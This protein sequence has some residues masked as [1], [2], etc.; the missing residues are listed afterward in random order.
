[1]RRPSFPSPPPS[2]DPERRPSVELGAGQV[3]IPTD[4]K[5]A[6]VRH[7]EDLYRLTDPHLSELGLESLLDTILTRIRQ[8]LAVDTVAVLLKDPAGEELVARA[9]KGLEAEVEQRVRI[10]IG[11]GFAGRIAA[12]R[13]AIFIP[14]VGQA[15]VVNPILRERGIRSM[16]GVPL[17]VEGELIGVLHVGSLTPRSFGEGDAAL[18]ALAAAR[19]APAIERARLSD[20]LTHHRV[21]AEALQ[22]G[23]L[24]EAVP[25]LP[26]VDVAVRYI[27]ARDEVGGD[28][29]EVMPLPGGRTGFVIGDVV[30]HGVRAAALMGQ[31][32]AVLRSAA[33]G[34]VQPAVVVA[35][36][37]RY[38]Q[39]AHP[40]G[41]ATVLYAVLDP[42]RG[43]LTFVRAGHPPLA[44]VGED[45]A[46]LVSGGASPPIGALRYPR[47]TEATVPLAPG[48]GVL[49]YTDGLVERRGESLDV[50]F[51]RLLE[52]AEGDTTPDL[53]CGR[54]ID[55]LIGSFASE[56]DVAVVAFRRPLPTPDLE[57]ESPATPESLAPTRR[58]LR[59]WLNARGVDA[60]DAT[61]IVLAT[62][63]A[64]ANAVEHAHAG[65]AGGRY[66][67][68]ATHAGDVVT[69]TVADDGD[70]R[71]PR[72][73]SDR[74]RGLPMIRSA[75]DRLVLDRD[76][77]GTRLTMTRA[78]G[79]GARR[80]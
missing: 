67:L 46:R 35:E 9:A 56:D 12:A 80:A 44:I 41:M 10:P 57:L 51:A 34:S 55:R 39:H 20:E 15:D 40:A 59:A 37:D 29:Y 75:M 72:S 32:R 42:D 74:G 50:G 71:V 48:D 69:V 6:G 43:T 14:E 66:V 1:M 49:L 8:I 61:D 31:L 45:G 64:L 52:A 65:R 2:R 76:G 62:G 23:L 53:L 4:L 73:G 21:I 58:R 68:R 19:V 38:L 63:E 79:G 17:I 11:Q 60:A 16:L 3:Q 27:P 26:D 7:R 33:L 25:E 24:P 54:V 5:A 30:G 28:W 77:G 47:F 78:V 18:L 36:V 22:R 13:R 70:W